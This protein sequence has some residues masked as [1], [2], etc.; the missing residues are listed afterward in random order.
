MLAIFCFLGLNV[1]VYFFIYFGDFS[2]NVPSSIL[3]SN[4]WYLAWFIFMGKKI[5]KPLLEASLKR[6]WSHKT[7]R[8]L[9]VFP[10]KEKSNLEIFAFQMLELDFC[11]FRNQVIGKKNLKDFLESLLQIAD[12]K[13]LLWMCVSLNFMFWRLGG[14]K[15]GWRLILAKVS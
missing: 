13:P 2:F 11:G 8:S 9:Y 14:R 7:W 5:T 10:L 1:N 6:V 4:V 12:V 3:F 15:N